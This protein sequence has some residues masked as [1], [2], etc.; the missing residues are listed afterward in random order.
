MKSLGLLY[1]QHTLH[2]FLFFNI[3]ENAK[4]LKLFRD[5]IL[6]VFQTDYEYHIS[7]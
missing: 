5:S 3:V 2:T 1:I 4:I 7:I 6:E